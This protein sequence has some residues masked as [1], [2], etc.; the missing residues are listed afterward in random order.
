MQSRNGHVDHGESTLGPFGVPV[1][2]DFSSA[3]DSDLDFQ[4]GAT[5]Q[6]AGVGH[7]RKQ[8]PCA[9]C[10]FCRLKDLSLGGYGS[11]AVEQ[12]SIQT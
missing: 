5:G 7:D 9:S 8:I 3:P 12:G 1:G 11:G 6:H 4:V 2:V 10:S